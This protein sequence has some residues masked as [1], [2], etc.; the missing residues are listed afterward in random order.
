MHIGIA[1]DNVVCVYLM[2]CLF[3]PLGIMD[4]LRSWKRWTIYSEDS[5]T[6]SAGFL[7]VRHGLFV[8]YRV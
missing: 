3:P 2:L 6:T 7:I 4:T 5:Y 8:E 1:R